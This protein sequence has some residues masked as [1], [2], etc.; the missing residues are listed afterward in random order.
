MCDPASLAIAGGVVAGAGSL[1]SGF[2]A[3]QSYG[4][5]AR[6]ADRQAT[7]EN[8]A[9]Y[10][11]MSRTRDRNNRVIAD[12]KQQYVSAGIDPSSGSAREVIADSAREASLDEQA[13]LYGAQVRA[14]NRR[15]EAR[16]ARSNATSALIGG[17]IN[18]GSSLVGG[19]SQAST[20]NAQR[21]MLTNPYAAYRPAGTLGGLY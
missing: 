17:V 10:Y 9:G 19:F 21:T 14:E 3:A 8:Q 6:M 7:M 18:A 15:F 1:Y 4:D 12:A 16:L 13:V 5:Q 11:E 20:F 2:T